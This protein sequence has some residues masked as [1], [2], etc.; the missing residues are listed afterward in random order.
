MSA[1]QADA[2]AW[3][4]AR[5]LA[6]P[7]DGAGSKLHCIARSTSSREPPLKVRR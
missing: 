5:L 2:G 3:T 1:R 4:D 6:E 7:S